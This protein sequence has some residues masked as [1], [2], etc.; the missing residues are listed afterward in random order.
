MM[1]R[2]AKWLPALKRHIPS[3]TF[4]F[5]MPSEADAAVGGAHGLADMQDYHK[6]NVTELI[7][8]CIWNYHT[9]E[10]YQAASNLTSREATL[11]ATEAKK[12]EY[13]EGHVV[14]LQGAV[15]AA[16]A[17]GKPAKIIKQLK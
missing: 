7:L 4:N 11:V 14:W 5:T 16:K 2:T 13:L 8:G 3:L 12:T 10:V 17:E 1:L 9:G 6:L 15:H